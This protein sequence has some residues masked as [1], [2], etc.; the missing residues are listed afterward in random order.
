DIIDVGLIAALSTVWKKVETPSR[1]QI[2]TGRTAHQCQ[3]ANEL[4]AV[5]YDQPM[6]RDKHRKPPPLLPKS[7]KVSLS[8]GPRDYRRFHAT[9]AESQVRPVCG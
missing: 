1:P 4:T 6:A 2:S 7:Q 5:I 3:S 9:A 8:F